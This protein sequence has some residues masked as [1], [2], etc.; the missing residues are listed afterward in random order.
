[1][2]S[3][4]N[5]RA[6][7]LALALERRSL[8]GYESAR[9]ERTTVLALDEYGNWRSSNV[10]RRDCFGASELGFGR[11]Q[12]AVGP[13]HTI[14]RPNRTRSG[15]DT[16]HLT[17]P[18]NPRERTRLER[19]LAA[20]KGRPAH[21]ALPIPSARAS[22]NRTLVGAKAPRPLRS[23]VLNDAA[24]AEELLAD[25]RRFLASEKAYA[26]R[27]IPYRRGYLLH[28]A[29]GTGKTSLVLALA[30]ELRLR[31]HVVSAQGE[32]LNDAAFAD[33]LR[34]AAS[35][36]ILLLEDID[37]AFARR[38]ASADAPNAGG[39][40]FSGLLNALDGVMA[41]EGSLVFMTTNHLDR[42]HKEPESYTCFSFS[43]GRPKKRPRGSRTK[44]KTEYE[45]ARPRRPPPAAKVGISPLCVVS[46][47]FCAHRQRTTHPF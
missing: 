39:L 2:D 29:P 36:S 13:G 26:E 42:T 8:A 11:G 3:R 24:A 31:L 20:Q 45:T 19:S 35:P 41:Q 14:D 37:A 9:A 38:P 47:R 28:G 25:C 46:R 18:R 7:S 22:T 21:L 30:S 17:T 4:E 5:A 23:V 16:A 40:S 10:R 27:G 44:I 33:A 6:R 43:R 1:M 15:R 34:S 12:D 32:T